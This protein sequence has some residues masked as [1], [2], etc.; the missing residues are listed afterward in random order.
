MVYPIVLIF[1]IGPRIMMGLLQQV[2]GYIWFIR[3][4]DTRCP[5][6]KRGSGFGTFFI[7]L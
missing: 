7:E 3:G 6:F 1:C 4:G 5:N 2:R